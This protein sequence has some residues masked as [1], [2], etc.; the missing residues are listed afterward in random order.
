MKFAL[1]I[2]ASIFVWISG[3]NAQKVK[4]THHCAT[5][6]G[7]TGISAAYLAE[8]SA[9]YNVA[10]IQTSC[11]KT[12]TKT[13]VQ[14]AEGKIDITASPF[15]LNFLMKKAL[16]P[17]AGL[18]KKKGADYANRLRILYAYDIAGFYLVSFKT[19]GI[20]SWDKLKGKKIFNGP[21]R[22][23]AT[24]TAKGIIY[25]MSGIK[26]GKGY[27][28]KHVSWPQSYSIMLDG[29]VDASV[30]PGT[31]PPAW[32]PI[33]LAAGKINI[34]SMTKA[35]WEGKGFQKLANGP[36]AVPLKMP[37]KDLA[38]GKHVISEDSYFRGL[39]QQ[40]GDIVNA[41]MS[42]ALAKKLTAA[43]IKD[44]DQLKKKTPWAAGANYGNPDGNRM[45]FCKKV[46]V[47]FHPGAVEAWEE[48][49][50]KIPD[51]AKG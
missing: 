13:M 31:N 23:G 6:D 29:S 7:A 41:S 10:T 37:I 20:D 8:V 46:G 47:K 50:R 26:E 9:K 21:P 51:C 24:T 38:F 3:V 40:A 19:K 27:T 49:G 33:F 4:L 22:G 44:L 2:F 45:G 12:L 32:V 48:A 34:V 30:R 18:G 17:Y 36:G 39:V 35:K 15:I 14:V 5:S 25:H 28:A 43:F 42:K 1:T 16:G 11:G